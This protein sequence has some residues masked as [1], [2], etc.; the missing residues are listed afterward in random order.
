MWERY[1]KERTATTSKPG[2]GGRCAIFKALVF[3]R[4][5][6]GGLDIECCVPEAVTSVIVAMVGQQSGKGHTSVK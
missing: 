1:S 3:G 2:C 6:L 5:V 4:K